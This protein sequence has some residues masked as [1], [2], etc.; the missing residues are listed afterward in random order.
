MLIASVEYS[1]AHIGATIHPGGWK[2][3]SYSESN[4]NTTPSF[5][6]GI[7]CNMNST[8]VECFDNVLC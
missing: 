8:C 3:G 7:R 2:N 1:T 4:V 6:N 5:G